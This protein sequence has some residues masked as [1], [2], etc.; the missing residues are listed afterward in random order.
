VILAHPDRSASRPLAVQIAEPAVLVAQG[1]GLLVLMPE[2]EQ[3]QA[4]SPELA[5]NLVPVGTVAGFARNGGRFP[6]EYPAGIPRNTQKMPYLL[7]EIPRV[8]LPPYRPVQFL[9]SS[10][11]PVS[12]GYGK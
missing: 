6:S 3:R 2:K 9:G 4:L 8:R 10:S 7:V 1:V 5:R 11:L 12:L